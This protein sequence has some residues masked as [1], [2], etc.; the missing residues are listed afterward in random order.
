MKSVRLIAVCMALF[1]TQIISAQEDKTA[2]AARA[3]VEKSAHTDRRLLKELQKEQ[4][5][6][7]P[8]I[9][10]SSALKR[11]SKTA[12]RIKAKGKRKHHCEIKK[13]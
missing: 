13:D 3:V 12:A 2:P 11:D 6:A 1:T 10:D 8:V 9:L 5:T 4:I 7:A